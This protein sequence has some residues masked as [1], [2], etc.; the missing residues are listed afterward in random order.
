MS[1]KNII[2]QPRAIALI[3]SQLKEGTLKGSYLFCGPSGIGKTLT[4]LA[5]AKALNCQEQGDDSC[6]ACPSCR[7]IDGLNHPDVFLI[8]KKEGDSQ[9]KVDDIRLM[10]ERI[11]LRPF[12]AKWKV[13]II[14]DAQYLSLESANCL[15]KALEEPPDNSLIILTTSNSAAVI[16]TII[17]RCKKVT[18]GSLP[19]KAVGDILSEKY[20]LEADTSRFLAQFSGGS[21]GEAARFKDMDMLVV[22]NSIIDTFLFGLY[23]KVPSAVFD[24]EREDLRF[25][26]AVLAAY[27]RDLW[28]LKIGLNSRLINE[29]RADNLESMSGRYSFEEL[30]AAFNDLS[31]LSYLA[32]RNVSTKLIFNFLRLRLCK[33]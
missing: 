27:L 4:A 15:L 1:F 2:G 29:D 19:L 22:K 32:E 13:F 8:E 28:M 20:S 23:P 26:L 10:L 24:D 11:A 30:D 12:E 21:P 18:F 16:P 31:Q 3:K 25:T 33:R 7:K 5:L 14:R 6:G 17:S 9:I